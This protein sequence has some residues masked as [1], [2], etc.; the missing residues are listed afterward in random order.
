METVCPKKV[1]LN[2]AIHGEYNDNGVDN[3]NALEEEEENEDEEEEEED[4]TKR[5]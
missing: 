4:E 2:S 1:S 5:M 3:V